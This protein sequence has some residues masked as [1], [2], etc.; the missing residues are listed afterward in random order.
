MI[1][2]KLPFSGNTIEEVINKIKV[3]SFQLDDIFD[4][5]ARNL[6]RK[7]LIKNP[8][9]R[10]SI[11]QVLEHPFL[12]LGFKYI[13]KINTFGLKPCSLTTRH[14][15][16]QILDNG[17]VF[18]EILEGSRIATIDGNGDCIFIQSPEK[19]QYSYPL[20][21]K[22]L[23]TIY[24]YAKSLIGMIRRKYG[25]INFIGEDFEAF[26]FKGQ[27][28]E[29]CISFFG[30]LNVAKNKHSEE[31][32]F[33]DNRQ[34]KSYKESLERKVCHDANIYLKKAKEIYLTLCSAIDSSWQFIMK[35]NC[36]PLL[37]YERVRVRE[38]YVEKFINDLEACQK[39]YIK[40]VGWCLFSKNKEFVLIFDDESTIFID[41]ECNKIGYLP[42][43]PQSNINWFSLDKPLPERT[44]EKLKYLPIFVNGIKFEN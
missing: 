44:K 22:K 13:N 1:T 42:N 21:N 12:N 37:L 24:E 20:S 17:D 18:V 4:P 30:C 35:N 15:S 2:G 38:H 11:S 25:I 26:L 23:G 7:M 33:F 9:K 32:L 5:L 6:I 8:E 3:V 28:Y 29:F 10:I 19:A 39:I 40:G 27:K 16:F 41:V 31:F 43:K 36:L 14:G 34:M